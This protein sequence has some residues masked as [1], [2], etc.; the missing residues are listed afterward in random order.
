MS[1]IVQYEQHYAALISDIKE[2][3]GRLEEVNNQS[4]RKVLCHSIRGSLVEAKRIFMQMRLERDRRSRGEKLRAAAAELNGLYVEYKQAKAKGR[5]LTV[6]LASLDLG[7]NADN[8]EGASISNDQQ[9]PELL[10]N[11]EPIERTDNKLTEG[12]DEAVET[13]AVESEAVE[14]EAVGAQ[15]LSALAPN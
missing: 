8:D 11:L 9:Q 7:S 5:S 2:L 10:D 6:A 13:E 15:E 12:Y 14:T 3:V 1:L 4:D